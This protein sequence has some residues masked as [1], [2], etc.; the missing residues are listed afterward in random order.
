MKKLLV[1]SLL[2]AAI[3]AAPTVV[4]AASKKS[5]KAAAA[6]SAKH[7]KAVPFRGTVK[8]VDKLAKTVTLAGKDHDRLLQVT[9]DTRFTKGGKPAILEDV[10]EGANVTGAYKDIDGKMNL[11]SLT[12]AEDDGKK[13][14]PK[15]GKKSS[16]KS[17]KSEGGDA[18]K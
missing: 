13:A 3:V 9:S 14:E 12:I 2:A 18:A 10:A 8:A 4:S 15:D 16:K 6:D 11:V 5:D 7:A 1:L 17:K